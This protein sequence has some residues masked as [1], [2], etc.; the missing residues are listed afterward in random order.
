MI[1]NWTAHIKDPD[2]KARF[3]KYIYGS[4]SLLDRMNVL[5]DEYENELDRSETDPSSYDSPSWAARQAHKNG[6]REC[7]NKIKKLTILDPKEK[8]DG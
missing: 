3:K 7:L 1:P 5:L 2:E 8:I 6:Y 4:K